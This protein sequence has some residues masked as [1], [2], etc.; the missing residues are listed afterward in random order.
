MLAQ[1][2]RSLLGRGNNQ[3]A[4]LPT[5]LDYR[6][7]AAVPAASPPPTPRRD[8][9]QIVA[10]HM[11]GEHQSQPKRFLKAVAH[12]CREQQRHTTLRLP[13]SNRDVAESVKPVPAS[14][15]GGPPQVARFPGHSPCVDLRLQQ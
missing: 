7:E 3:I 1:R 2:L 8:Y 14:I 5:E 10:R 9:V 13:C 11:S 6:Q 12:L 15:G 4:P